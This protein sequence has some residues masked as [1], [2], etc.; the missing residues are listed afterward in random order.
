MKKILF[1]LFAIGAAVTIVML[2]QSREKTSRRNNFTNR[3]LRGNIEER[4]ERDKQMLWG[5][6]QNVVGDFNTA[7]NKI[8]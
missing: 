8:A 6:W 4:L 7:F 5:D 1:I 2:F 3:S